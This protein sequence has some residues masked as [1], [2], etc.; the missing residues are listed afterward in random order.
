M[1]Y[2]W[3]IS[4]FVFLAPPDLVTIETDYDTNSLW[5][6]LCSWIRSIFLPVDEQQQQETDTV[7]FRNQLSE[8]D[9]IEL[10]SIDG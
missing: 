10:P 1:H 9:P 4:F 8:Y 3:L 7:I 2:R 5:W 6:Q